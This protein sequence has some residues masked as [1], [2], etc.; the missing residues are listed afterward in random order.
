MSRA[1]AGGTSHTDALSR[2]QLGAVKSRIE[3]IELVRCQAIGC[4]EGV[5]RLAVLNRDLLGAGRCRLGAH[6]LPHL[7]S[8]DKG[9]PSD[10]H[11]R[12]GYIPLGGSLV[13]ALPALDRE[14]GVLQRQDRMVYM[15]LCS[16]LP[17]ANLQT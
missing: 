15:Q 12:C 17:S 1:A 7:H 13:P 16:V 9:C 6:R 5:A 10:I 4:P 14:N 11:L 8:T 3:C 2:L